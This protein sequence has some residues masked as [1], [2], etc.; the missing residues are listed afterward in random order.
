MREKAAEVFQLF[1]DPPARIPGRNPGKGFCRFMSRKVLVMRYILFEWQR[2]SSA[3][4]AA[5]VCHFRV[6]SAFLPVKTYKIFT[7]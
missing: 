6:G 1:P 3:V 4:D 2:M 5:D 7:V